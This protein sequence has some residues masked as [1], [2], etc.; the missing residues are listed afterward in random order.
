MNDIAMTY[1]TYISSEARFYTIKDL[2][3]MLGW[4]AATVHKLFNDPEFP[5]T[6]FGKNKVVEAHALINFFSMRHE[7]EKEKYW[8]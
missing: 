4:S 6:D 8:K 5:A 1:K 3:D 7:R 2:Q